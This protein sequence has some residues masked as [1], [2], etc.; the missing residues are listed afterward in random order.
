M[1]TSCG[2]ACTLDW[3]GSTWLRGEG[4]FSFDIWEWK[5]LHI[6][7]QVVAQVVLWWARFTLV[8]L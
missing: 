5:Q 3:N 8:F 2:D 7:K 6:D 1:S 4:E